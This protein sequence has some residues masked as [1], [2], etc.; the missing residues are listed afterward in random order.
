MLKPAILALALTTPFAAGALAAEPPSSVE[1][2]LMTAIE[3][4]ETSETATLEDEARN[5]IE[6][7]LITL[8]SHCEAKRFSEAATLIA[9]IQTSLKGS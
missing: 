5:K 8:E 7:H 1:D 3:L 4:A 6:N 2:C 9:D